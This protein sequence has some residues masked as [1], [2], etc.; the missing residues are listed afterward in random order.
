MHARDLPDVSMGQI[1]SKWF[2]DDSECTF[3]PADMILVRVRIGKVA[4]KESLLATIRGTPVKQGTAGW[5]CIAWVKEALE[6]VQSDGRALSKHLA[7][8]ETIRTEAMQYVEKKK[9]QHRFDGK[10]HV[11]AFDKDVVPTWDMMKKKETMA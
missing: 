10:A 6:R 11:G 5:N 2:F 4:N 3:L 8:W 7:D 9:A 1:S